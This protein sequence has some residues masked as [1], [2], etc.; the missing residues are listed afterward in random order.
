MPPA[1]SSALHNTQAH[2]V[3]ARLQVMGIEDMT[4]EMRR[5]PYK[6]H[7]EEDGFNGVS[8]SS[9]FN[10]FARNL[11]VRNAGEWPAQAAAW[12]IG[13]TLAL[14]LPQ[15]NSIA[16][17]RFCQDAGHAL[18]RQ[19]GTLVSSSERF[20][21]Y[22]M[23]PS[24]GAFISQAN[25]PTPAASRD[26]LQLPPP[27]WQ[28]AVCALLLLC[29]ADSSLGCSSCNH[30]TFMGIL[31]EADRTPEEGAYGHHGVT[32]ARGSYNL[33]TDFVVAAPQVRG[34][35]GLHKAV[36]CW[37][38]GCA[39]THLLPLLLCAP[40][41]QL[42]KLPCTVSLPQHTQLHQF[43]CVRCLLRL[44]SARRSE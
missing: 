44:A 42:Q 28:I 25:N 3:L 12:H 7:F 29:P 26:V 37:Q 4:V 8:F 33:V 5:A 11:R 6:G 34:G 23:F 18:A 13:T 16:C 27:E 39:F 1:A 10:C 38:V 21:K 20:T 31:I 15:T 17:S 32:L 2:R 40:S 14:L 19:Q 41:A 43:C 36:S 35:G 9:A 24:T 22:C 30:C